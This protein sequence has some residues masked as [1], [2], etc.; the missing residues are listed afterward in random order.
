MSIPWV[1]IE[2]ACTAIVSGLVLFVEK[3]FHID[4]ACALVIFLGLYGI[5][6]IWKECVT[7]TSI[8]LI[9]ILLFDIYKRFKEFYKEYKDKCK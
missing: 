1:F 8:I 3:R 9:I 7:A 2:V 6:R 4:W 5:L